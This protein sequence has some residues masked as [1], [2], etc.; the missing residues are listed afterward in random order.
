MIEIDG[1]AGEGGGQ[2]LR[3]ALS[4][5]MITQTPFR[6]HGIRAR[7]PKPGLLRQ[8]LTAVEAAA[9][10]S[11]A[12]IEGGSLGSQQLSFKPGPVRG[13]DYRYA[14]GTAGSCTLVLQTL[15]PALWFADGPARVAVSGGTHNPYAP[16]MDFL[17]RA[18]LPL[19]TRMGASTRLELLR[20]G[21]Y[22]AGGG[23]VAATVEPCALRPLHLDATGE[24]RGMDARALIAAVPRN[25][26]AREL[27]C[28]T[29]AFEGVSTVVRDLP[30]QEGPGNALTLALE[31]EHVTEVFCGIGQRG[32][33]AESVAKAVVNAARAYIASGAAV[34]EY[35]A[36]QLILPIALAGAGRF[37]TM[38][39]SSHLLTNIG[40]VER[41]LPI[42]FSVAQ[43]EDESERW[44]V[45][46]Q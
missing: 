10:L 20:H 26:A 18:W 5:A 38:K 2:T 41:F 37:T 1:A 27:G 16:P 12:E 39:P 25:V 31:Y 28:V 13:G 24:A 46:A 9:E 11:G 32:R 4:L 40:V 8:H 35:L 15:L 34:A 22:P 45:N 36:D 43:V 6:I 3:T 23:E 30:R 42:R 33:S 44:V 21:F 14:I 19:V 7:R 17:Q 29:R